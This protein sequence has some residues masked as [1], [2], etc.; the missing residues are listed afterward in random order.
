MHIPSTLHEIVE[1]T[2]SLVQW[3]VTDG[4]WAFGFLV[5]TVMLKLI[6]R[7]FAE[8]PTTTLKGEGKKSSSFDAYQAVPAVVG[9]GSA[10]RIVGHST[11]ADGQVDDRRA[12]C[13]QCELEF[14]KGTLTL[15]DL[16]SRNCRFVNDEH[17]DTLADAALT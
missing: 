6:A 7:V 2:P 1:Y 13:W 9:H 15:R 4:V 14:S 5:L 12:S 3:K 8:G 11:V 10:F 17:V 16:R